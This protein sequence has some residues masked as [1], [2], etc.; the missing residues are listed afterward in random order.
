M[1]YFEHLNS[2]G[3]KIISVDKAGTQV[4]FTKIEYDADCG[5]EIQKKELALELEEWKTLC[6]KWKQISAFLEKKSNSKLKLTLK[7]T[8]KEAIYACTSVF[9]S[10]RFVDIRQYWLPKDSDTFKPTLKGICL[11]S[12]EWESLVKKHMD[13]VCALLAAT[14]TEEEESSSEEEDERTRMNKKR[15][16][17]N[18]MQGKTEAEGRKNKLSHQFPPFSHCQEQGSSSSSDE[19]EEEDRVIYKRQ[20]RKKWGPDRYYL[21]KGSKRTYCGTGISDFYKKQAEGD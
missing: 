2:Q 9:N 6:K 4:R 12:A 13:Q 11:N 18:W 14:D 15:K 16:L 17:S 3:T 1:S 7:E 20:H 21:P 19:E 8:K 5:E 10:K